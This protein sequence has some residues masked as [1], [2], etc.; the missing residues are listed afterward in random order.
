MSPQETLSTN[1]TQTPAIKNRV[2]PACGTGNSSDSKFCRQC[3][4]L[5]RAL[6][7]NGV[8]AKKPVS[9]DTEDEEGAL[10]SPAEID[11]RRSHQLLDRAL[12]MSERGD[13]SAALLAC[14][15]A[16]ALDSGHA[17][18]YALLATL[19]ERSGDLRGAVNAYE[20]L[21]QISPDNALERDSL[22]RLKTRLEKAPAFNFNPNELFADN[23]DTLPSVAAPEVQPVIAP[24]ERD[25]HGI[26]ARLP[27][28]SASLGA[29]SAPAVAAAAPL[30]F[31]FDAAPINATPSVSP[32]AGAMDGEVVSRVGTTAPAS[33]TIAPVVA[34]SSG[35]PK[36]ERRT[37][38]RRQV[39][40]PVATERRTS[41]ERRVPS[42]R[43]GATFSPSVWPA[44]GARPG[45]SVPS[46]APTRTP[47]A[48][49]API[50]FS[51][52]QTALVKA[53]LWAQMMR[54]SSF[55]ART[56]PLVAV[57]IVG[58]GFLSW[59]RSQAVARDALNGSGTSTL[60]VSPDGSTTTT[61][62]QPNTTQD[63]TTI[64]P[65][66][67]TVPVVNPNGG[68]VPITNATS[69]PAP[70]T[71][72]N[73]GGVPAT[74]PAR[75]A[76]PAPR[77]GAGGGGSTPVRATGGAGTPNFPLAPAPVP[78]A[79][80]PNRSG[81]NGGGNNS[82]GGNIVLPPPQTQGGGGGAGAPIPVGSLGSTPL[83]PSGSPQEG[84]IRITQGSIVGR[85][86]A[87]PRS[88]TQAR[89]DERP[90]AA[91]AAA[92]NPN[93]AINNLSNA[94][95]ATGSDQGFLLQQRAMAFLDRGDAAR[96]AE[97]FSAAINAYQEQINRGE[98]VA[99]AQSG[100]RAARQGLNL[101]QS[102]R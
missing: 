8:E 9:A 81:A 96:A 87:P 57:G 52:G 25:E 83:N 6:G 86:A 29:T 65:G 11:A 7:A 62:I 92:G 71:A 55:F 21:L 53:P 3:G 4:H 101:A 26:E 15:Q 98:N 45:L 17:E 16:V 22:A 82:A 28:T 88:G 74:N 85:P 19:L 68:G 13:L 37:H 24:V 27:P 56:L 41:S 93:G 100:Q 5:L 50:D 61:V 102:R 46:P 1:T 42:T 69:A 44:P 60:V 90:G 43:A 63:G 91:A 12:L 75:G 80:A 30:V 66:G 70:A 58:L 35:V 67:A 72:T 77:P 39:N 64:V 99:A 49:I 10:T 79:P 73:A 47:A 51:F 34:P 59:A 84:R 31:E 40:V 38:Q 18:P 94:I 48:A 23:D 14:R 78:P 97:D 76:A 20:R 33:N 95:N 36:I 32:L 2:C 89:G 54:G